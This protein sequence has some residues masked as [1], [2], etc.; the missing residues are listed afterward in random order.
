MNRL[1][2][3][4]NAALALALLTLVS[5]CFVAI[6][7]QAKKD[8][9]Y[10]RAEAVLLVQALS[11]PEGSFTLYQRCKVLRVIKNVTDERFG[12]EVDVIFANTENG[13][14]KAETIVFLRRGGR[15]GQ[16]WLRLPPE[17]G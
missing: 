2:A 17:K 9:R 16:E 4:R 6:E 1:H 11:E 3:I 13:L 14:T 7:A 15:K 12:T 10:Q 5:G 8:L